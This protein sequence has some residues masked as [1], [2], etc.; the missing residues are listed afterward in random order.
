MNNN[1]NF[2]IENFQD[3]HTQGTS[4]EAKAV[5]NRIYKSLERI[6]FRLQLHSN[7]HKLLREIAR[8][9]GGDISSED[10][11]RDDIYFLD[12]ELELPASVEAQLSE[13][14]VRER[15]YNL[16]A[17]LGIIKKAEQIGYPIGAKNGS[18]Y[19]FTGTHWATFEPDVFKRFLEKCYL[20]TG[21][22]MRMAKRYQF[23]KQGLE[24]FEE[25]ALIM[26]E[27][28]LGTYLNLKKGTLVFD[29]NGNCELRDHSAQDFITYVLPYEYDEDARCPMFQEYLNYVVPEEDKQKVL[30]E[31]IG[32]VFSD[33][34]HEKVLILF[35]SGRNG[36]S[37]FLM[38]M[39]A[40]L[41]SE[42]V[43]SHTLESLTG[44]NLYFVGDL[45]D[46][47][48]NFSG[49][50]STKVN[51]DMFKKLA[52]GEKVTARYP[53]GRPFEVENYAR[54]AFNCNE[55]PEA[56]ETTEGF[57]RRFLIIPFERYIPDDK[58][59]PNLAEKIIANELPGIINWV[60]AGLMRLERNNK[61][62]HCESAERIL[63]EFKKE[64]DPVGLFL[65]DNVELF[66]K[67]MK[68]SNL[69]SLYDEYCRDFELG[70]LGQKQFAQQLQTKGINKYRKSDGNYYDV[71]EYQPNSD[72]M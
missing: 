19:I 24:Q 10:L 64:S 26:R 61:F 16:I 7:R 36:K 69:Y 63:K 34:K 14:N 62:T 15:D 65:E 67:P 43:C 28:E 17:T 55:L 18:I 31:F 37:V 53:Y 66:D 39:S 3:N 46:C 58:V 42:N 68:A 23:L 45:A 4:L 56:E 30:A 33:L 32:S 48:L 5:L 40:L 47:L 25:S 8:K 27:E 54:L 29:D 6:N 13:I 12:S 72:K 60:I 21:V 38:I 1:N 2:D 20:R 59:D 35:G 9:N 52:S 41:G 22:P 71:H 70:K 49:E 50:I 51:P 11:K 57:F 44:S